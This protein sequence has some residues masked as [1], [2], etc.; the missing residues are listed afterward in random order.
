MRYL[1]HLRLHGSYTIMHAPANINIY[2]KMSLQQYFYSKKKKRVNLLI[3]GRL[4]LRYNLLQR[5]S[6]DHSGECRRCPWILMT[7]ECCGGRNTGSRGLL[8]HI[9]DVVGISACKISLR[10][11]M[12]SI[13]GGL[14]AVDVLCRF[15]VSSSE[16]V[17][18]YRAGFAAAR[19]PRLSMSTCKE[20]YILQYLAKACWLFFQFTC[21]HA[22]IHRN[23][24]EI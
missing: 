2:K 20:K 16:V 7:C 22:C 17:V 9:I 19:F 4:G 24:T 8:K 21:M 1:L 15:G 13:I 3:I 14:G 10:S 11:W 12:S 5:P 23:I 6:L 18:W